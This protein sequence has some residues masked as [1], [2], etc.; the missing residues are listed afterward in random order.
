MDI[1]I[2]ADYAV[3]AVVELARSEDPVKCRDIAATQGIPVK[4]LVQIFSDLR[5]VGL[6]RSKRGANGGYWLAMSPS[7]VSVAAVVSAVSGPLV[8][9]QG[10]SVA[11][12]PESACPV[13]GELDA[14]V[15][16]TL[17]A[18]SVWDLASRSLASARS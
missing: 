4:F 1:P 10:T 16:R 13:W 5:R 11:H 14:Q 3:R 18:V 7:D 15:R 9:L 2:K 17:E 8:T 12:A 6:V